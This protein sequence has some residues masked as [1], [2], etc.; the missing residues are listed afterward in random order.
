MRRV[1]VSL[2]LFDSIPTRNLIHNNH[3]DVILYPF[4]QLRIKTNAFGKGLKLSRIK[5]K[6]KT[7]TLKT[8]LLSPRG[9]LQLRKNPFG[10]PFCNGVTSRHLHFNVSYAHGLMA[11]AIGRTEVGI[12][13][14]HINPLTL[15]APEI[16]G[17]NGGNRL[18]E[19]VNYEASYKAL[20]LGIPESLSDFT[21]DKDLTLFKFHLGKK[22]YLS[23]AIRK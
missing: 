2:R 17:S 12:D 1:S 13:V 11:I 21:L 3:Y 19:W 18:E 16:E 8:Y 10:K 9:T 4:D 23:L 22:H 14:E 20:G 7:I 6:I 5:E 15:M